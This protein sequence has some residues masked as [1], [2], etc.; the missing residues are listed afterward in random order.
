VPEEPNNEKLVG[1]TMKKSALQ[2]LYQD[3]YIDI[4]PTPGQYVWTPEMEQEL[5][6]LMEGEI[7]D[8][9]N[10][11]EMARAIEREHSFLET[12]LLALDGSRRRKVLGQVLQK[13]DDVE[14]DAIFL[15]LVESDEDV[16]EDDVDSDMSL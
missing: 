16:G 11:T 1:S 15:D 6:R 10:D 7:T 14:R 2:K 8:F 9:I 5:E 12:R 4:T 13:I 3:K